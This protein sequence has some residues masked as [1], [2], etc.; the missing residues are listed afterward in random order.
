MLGDIS[1]RGP[2]VGRKVC[3]DSSSRLMWA[4]MV[5]SLVVSVSGSWNSLVRD[6]LLVV[7][8]QGS[9]LTR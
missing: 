8:D 9:G 4:V 5:A 6:G 3:G 7:V 2:H 1:W